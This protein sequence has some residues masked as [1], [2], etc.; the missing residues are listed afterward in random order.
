MS[1]DFNDDSKKSLD[2]IKTSN[3]KKQEESTIFERISSSKLTESEKVI[4]LQ[5]E[6]KKIDKKISK[7]KKIQKELQDKMPE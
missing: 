2:V 4:L 3:K 6:L 1:N 5:R 7:L